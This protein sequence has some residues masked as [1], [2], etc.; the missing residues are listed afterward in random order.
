MINSLIDRVE[1]HTKSVATDAIGGQAVTYSLNSTIWA[2]VKPMNSFKV[3]QLGK[4]FEGTA[5]EI[6]ARRE[7]NALITPETKLVWE[8]LTLIVHSSVLE[9]KDAIKIVA[10]EEV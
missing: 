10:A 9:N 5:Y 8:G 4:T 6:R 2:S 7:H 3:A 1:I